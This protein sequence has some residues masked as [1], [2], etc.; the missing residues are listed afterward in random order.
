MLGAADV[1]QLLLE[2]QTIDVNLGETDGGGCTHGARYLDINRNLELPRAI[3]FHA[4]APLE[5]LR[6]MQF[7]GMLCG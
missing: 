4:F 3:A 7:N 6:C 2:Q 5:A 1:V